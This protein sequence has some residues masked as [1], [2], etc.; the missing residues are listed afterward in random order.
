MTKN[1][2]I[3]AVD[4]R[5]WQNLIGVQF[6]L[7]GSQ[8]PAT[9]LNCYGLVREVYSLLSMELPARPETAID[10]AALESE[11]LD[12]TET[13]KPAAWCVALYRSRPLPSDT[14]GGDRYHVGIVTSEL[15][16]LHSLP[17]KGVVVS[18]LERYR[19]D[20]VGYYL[21]TPGA[22]TMRLPH[23][24]GAVGKIV[25]GVLLMVVAAV[26]MVT[27]PYLAPVGAFMFKMGAML[28]ISGAV[29]GITQLMADKPS[30][31]GYGGDL[32]DSRTYSWDGIVNDFRQG[33][34]KPLLFGVCKVG[35]QIISEKTWFDGENHEYL[36]SLICPCLGPITRF[37]SLAINDTTIDYYENTAAVFRP[38]D[39][40]QLPISLFERIQIQY[41]AQAKLSQT[42]V[43]FQT[44]GSLSAIRITLAAPS[45]LYRLNKKGKA[46]PTSVVTTI[47]YKSSTI[48][49]WTN[50]PAG[51]PVYAPPLLFLDRAS[52]AFSGSANPYTLTDDGTGFDEVMTVGQLFCLKIGAVTYYCAQSGN[53]TTDTVGFNAYTDDARTVAVSGALGGG[54][55]CLYSATDIV[56]DISGMTTRVASGFTTT[57]ECSAVKFTVQAISD[58]FRWMALD[59][60]YRPV[61]GAWKLHSVFDA[62]YGSFSFYSGAVGNRY[63]SFEI[64]GLTLDRYQVV[65]NWRNDQGTGSSRTLDNLAIT[66]ICLDTLY[67]PGV[68][69]VS[70]YSPAPL[71]MSAKEIELTGL[72]RDDYVFRIWRT[73]DDQSGVSRQDA[74]YLRGYAEIVERSLAYP[75]HALMGVRAMATDRLYGGRPTITAIA[76]GAPLSVPASSITTTVATDEGVVA[77]SGNLINGVTVDGMRKIMVNVAL[78]SPSAIYYWLVRMDSAGMAQPDRLLT[79]WCCRVHTWEQVSGQTRLYVQNSELIASGASVMLFTET[80]APTRN[81]AWAVAKLLIE[82]SHGRITE[83]HIHW[84]S[85]AAWNEWNQELVNGE[86]RHQFDAVIDFSADLWAIALRAAATARGTLV[87]A[88]GKYKVIIDRAAT[89]VQLFGDGN[90]SNASVDFI[91]RSDRANILVGSFL[92]RDQSYEQRDISREDVQGAEYPIVTNYPVMV[93]V[94][95]ESQA[96]ALLDHTLRQNRYIERTI[97]FDVGIDSIEVEIGDVFLFASP[98]H[99]FAQ[100][101][102]LRSII[103]GAVTLDESF[104]PVDGAPYRLSVWLKDGLHQW[105]GPLTGTTESIPGALPG[106]S[107]TAYCEYPYLLVRVSEERP[108]YRV[109]KIKRVPE[110]MQATI[111]GVEYRDEIYQYD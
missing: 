90:S 72:P 33:L 30:L 59:V 95:R 38:G 52:G 6:A 1:K 36:D 15:T 44:K 56:P 75:N 68:F 70:G 92:D 88:G 50:I 83:N 27:A 111:T 46:L 17:R 49:E 91:P 81:T 43:T 100:S 58:L 66:G 37:E 93:G 34:V 40:E 78:P 24:D 84:D 109:T 31:S 64:T 3:I 80:D 5:D 14:A 32:A 19:D 77:G 39:D 21:Y 107:D 22:G 35:G 85:F 87:A 28:V 96:R 74:V 101:G 12:W 7:G 103:E 4:Y 99:D 104:T 79:K 2:R 60:W 13:D 16:L 53:L 82:G 89:P 57:V 86:P 26:M 76:T 61:G 8:T 47:Q 23:A 69:T 73:T 42:P 54:A 106:I 63:R 67:V 97:T 48:T 41:D 62:G 45:G 18:P 110:T 108:R 102:R 71:R 29:E 20:L 9:G 105:S 25:G 10:A 65:V 94:T 98:A 51:D 55:Y 11:A